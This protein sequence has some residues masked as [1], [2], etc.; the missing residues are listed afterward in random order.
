MMTSWRWTDRSHTRNRLSFPCDLAISGFNNTEV[1]KV[2]AISV[3]TV[4]YP[5]ADV[6]RHASIGARPEQGSRFHLAEEGCSRQPWSNA[7]PPEKT[8]MRRSLL[9]TQEDK[10]RDRQLPR[11]E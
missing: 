10:K 2:L 7:D 9:G 1:S 5:V 3:T 8:G 11:C 4:E 6:S